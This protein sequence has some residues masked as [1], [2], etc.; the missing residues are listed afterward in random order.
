[1][2]HLILA[3]A[4]LLSLAA[5][6]DDQKPS[7]AESTSPEI[8]IV[9]MGDS[10]TAGWGLAAEEAFPAKLERRLRQEGYNVRV[11]NS[12][13][14]G[15]TSSDALSRLDQI[16]GM[17]PDIVIVE[18]GA[19][20]GFRGTNPAV[21]RENIGKILTRLKEAG[22][23]P[24]LAGMKTVMSLGPAYVADFNA[25]YPDM[26]K[27]H[28]V[29]FMPFFLDGVAAKPRLNQDDGIHPKA[30]GYDI[31]VENILPLVRK[32]IAQRRQGKAPLH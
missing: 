18:T 25:I 8:T 31:V 30:A 15:E 7:A 23:I 32:A 1:M 11:V 22:V 19:N 16:L 5:C 2:K 12:G 28:G 26:A 3:A 29:L 27:K 20:D 6:H 9:A 10:L 4:L 17:N 24:I 13:V 21:L 14:S